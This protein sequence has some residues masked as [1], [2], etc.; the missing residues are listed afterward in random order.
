MKQYSF[1]SF[2]VDESNRAAFELCRAVADLTPV[3]PLPAMVLG[4]QGSGK[5]HLLYAIVNRIKAGSSKAGL[6][7]V[8]AQDFPDQVRALIDDP[9]P[10]ERAESAV[11]LVDQLDAFEDQVEELEAVVRIFLDN[12]HYVVLASRVH[13]G[14][15][16]QLGEGLRVLLEAG[17]AVE[18]QPQESETRI[19]V[20]ERRIGQEH[21][22]TLA[23]QREEIRELRALVERVGQGAG[24]GDT[25]ALDAL[26][27][28]LEEE[29]TAKGELSQRLDL[30]KAYSDSVQR[31]LAE[32]QQEVAR[33]KDGMAANGAQEGEADLKRQV[34]EA[35]AGQA[36]AA[37]EAERLREELARVTS[38]E[39]EVEQLR[40][41]LE[42]LQA[43]SHAA[44]P[45]A[46]VASLRTQLDAARNEG[47]QARHEANLMLERAEKLLGQIEVNR[48]RFGEVEKRNQARIRELEAS[49]ADRSG[50]G[51]AAVDLAATRAELRRAQSELALAQGEFTQERKQLAV[52]LAQM[53]QRLAKEMDE[54]RQQAASA[55]AARD[56]AVAET[57]ALVP[58]EM[59]TLRASLEELKE[60]IGIHRGELGQV[61]EERDA[62][63]A[64]LV[65]VREEGTA[66]RTELSQAREE[67]ASLRAGLIQ[68][69]EE[70]TALRAELSQVREEGESL[71]TELG[72]AREE[73]ESLRMELGQARGERD[74]LQ[75]EL[76][77][78]RGEHDSLEADMEALREERDALQSE[79][80]EVRDA[81]AMLQG[82]LDEANAELEGVRTQLDESRAGEA[83]LREKLTE[84]EGAL[85]GRESELD[86]LR[87]EAAEQVAEAQA[88]AGAL[89]GQLARRTEELE[90][91]R[92][93]DQDVGEALRAL[94]EGL[95]TS[96]E[97]TGGLVE[98]LVLPGEQEEEENDAEL[99]LAAAEL[100]EAWEPL[101]E[102]GP[103]MPS[104]EEIAAAVA[105]AGMGPE[106]EEA[107][108]ASS[109]EGLLEDATTSFP[110]EPEALGE[111][112]V[113]IPENGELA[114]AVESIETVDEAVDFSVPIR[115]E[116]AENEEVVA[117]DPGF[118]VESAADM[119][120]ETEGDEAGEAS[121]LTAG[122][123]L[124]ETEVSV[125]SA[126]PVGIEEDNP[127]S[128]PE[129]FSGEPLDGSE[130]TGVDGVEL[131]PTSVTPLED[132]SPLAD[133]EAEDVEQP[134][135]E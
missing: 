134:L 95:R 73:G 29:R 30:A 66:L 120:P 123:D 126:Q 74:V 100:P 94:Q 56:R 9:S 50:G 96:I 38:A 33:F 70:G 5:T 125:D 27:G 124:A 8:T 85:A 35:Q 13:P 64:G 122:G 90:Q 51:Q 133:D 101:A 11:L 21:E 14:R 81:R 23:K 86:A 77:A 112:D 84:T 37:G 24:T 39:E 97:K 31:D 88:Q 135:P 15:L 80:S 4:D 89:E 116:E 12:N 20:Q 59:V 92:L 76:D 46:E 127:F 117:Y 108:E 65:Q 1:N 132:L 17:Q 44:V 129:I 52:R 102:T 22:E 87:Q 114:E 60:E 6:A 104:D 72:Q 106:V 61:K 128:G 10:V 103:A 57:T 49:L 67:E 7:Y 93:T 99:P 25:R 111:V 53:Q 82:K 110:D 105:E 119:G 43:Q 45:A 109:E 115:E 62:L 18:I 26:Q 71:R 42:S 75:A 91:A 19:Q 28:Q 118:G 113:E 83:G 98:R 130:S 47:A 58:A 131:P 3:A 68:V 63:R 69:R 41:A 32:L 36:A 107:P 121:S 48:A 55:M 54:A 79:L 78:S 2:L 16:R 34:E 40:E